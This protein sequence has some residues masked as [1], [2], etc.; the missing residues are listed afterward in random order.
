MGKRKSTGSQG[1][2]KPKR[3]RKS[4]TQNNNDSS[5]EEVSTETKKNMFA[6]LMSMINFHRVHSFLLG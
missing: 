5:S 4:A 3:N 2:D 6:L 1:I